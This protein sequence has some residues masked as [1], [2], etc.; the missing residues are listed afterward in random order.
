MTDRSGYTDWQDWMRRQRQENVQ[1]I[2]DGHTDLRGVGRT[3]MAL[4]LA[5]RMENQHG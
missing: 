5:R 2:I 1:F 4:R 3:N